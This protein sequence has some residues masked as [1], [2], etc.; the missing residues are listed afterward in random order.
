MKI[1]IIIEGEELSEVIEFTHKALMNYIN[2]P[3]NPP[4]L[5]SMVNMVLLD[6]FEKLTEDE[7]KIFNLL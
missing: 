1:K 3:P 5:S 2:H 7:K 4:I 6:K